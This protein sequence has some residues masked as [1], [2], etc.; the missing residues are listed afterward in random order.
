[1]L[2]T[3]EE[4]EGIRIGG[5]I[6]GRDG[7]VHR[8][9][10]LV[11]RARRRHA[12]GREGAAIRPGTKHV[13]H[14]SFQASAAIPAILSF[15]LHRRGVGLFSRRRHVSGLHDFARSSVHCQP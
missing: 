9:M 6:E 12:V 14:R 11:G 1:M 10:P 3:G 7:S 13:E 15:T 4:A 2:K 8:P 5:V